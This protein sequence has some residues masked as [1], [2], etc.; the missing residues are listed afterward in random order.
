MSDEEREKLAERLKLVEYK[1]D[2]ILDTQKEEKGMRKWILAAILS[3]I[4]SAIML[5]MINGGFR[6]VN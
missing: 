4:V 3:P 1:V 6:V 2:Q 5:F